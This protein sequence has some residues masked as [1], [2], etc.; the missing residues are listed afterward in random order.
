[1]NFQEY[2]ELPVRELRP[3]NPQVR[4]D[5]LLQGLREVV[6]GGGTILTIGNGGSAATADH[7][8]ADLN[9]LRVRK[10]ILCKAIP[11]ASLLSEYTALSNDLGFEFVFSNLILSHATT[12]DLVVVFSASGSSPNLIK[13]IET[14]LDNGIPVYPIVGF[15][16]GLSLQL[17][18]NTIHLPQA[19]RNY[20][21]A[22]NFQ[23]ALCHY[24]S[25]RLEEFAAETNKSHER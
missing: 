5:Q 2:L 12:T 23:L 11:L 4:I 3:S 10:G 21:I 13:A 15:D 24:I 7:F 22:E 18:Q 16:G 17:S 19:D 9:L 14:C 25:D 6:I 1:M 8:A 20:G